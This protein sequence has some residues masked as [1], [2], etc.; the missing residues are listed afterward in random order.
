MVE[1]ISEPSRGITY[2]CKYP[3]TGN[4]MSEILQNPPNPGQQ[5]NGSNPTITKVAEENIAL[6]LVVK[7][8]NEIDFIKVRNII[9]K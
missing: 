2:G 9:H 8:I 5:P 4:V 6:F 1:I 7:K 3:N